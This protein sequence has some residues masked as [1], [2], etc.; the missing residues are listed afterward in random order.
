MPGR[1]REPAPGPDNTFARWLRSA[2]MARNLGV[3]QLAEA[4]DMAPPSVSQLLN[5]KNYPSAATVAKLAVFFG[6]PRRQIMEMLPGW[7]AEESLPHSSLIGDAT[8]V[9]MVPVLDQEAGAGEGVMVVDYVYL[10]PAIAAKGNVVGIKI[11]GDCM[12]P[13]IE[14]GDI[15]ILERGASWQPGRVIVAQVDEHLIVKRAVERKGQGVLLRADNPAYM[16]QEMIV[17][18]AAILGVVVKVTKDV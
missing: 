3:R 7:R 16:P 2:A 6:V 14:E 9:L 13:R 17:P 11:R 1:A 15:V 12:A 4:V 18:E 8:S 5:G 10:P